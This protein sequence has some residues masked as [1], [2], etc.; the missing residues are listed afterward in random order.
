MRVLLLPLLFSVAAAQGP[1]LD[2]LRPSRGERVALAA[3]ALAGGVG[4]SAGMYLVIPEHSQGE[5]GSIALVVLAYPVGV[6]AATLLTAGAL[7]LDADPLA[8][9]SDALLGAA[10]GALAGVVVGGA[11]AG[12]VWLS[13]S[14]DEYSIFTLIVGVGVASLTAAAVSATV[15]GRRVRVAPAALVAA[16]GAPAPGLSLR[17]DL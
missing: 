11:A 7:G 9:A 8:T 1:A 12:L 17:V 15:A 14:D 10:G 5:P 6:A 4:A 3:A 2:G 16:P 13:G